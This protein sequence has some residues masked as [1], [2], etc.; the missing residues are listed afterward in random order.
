MDPRRRA[1]LAFLA[2]AAAIKPSFGQS[3]IMTKAIPSTGEPVP[4]IG[5]GTWQTFDAG[6]DSAAR[7]PLREVL[8]L[9][10]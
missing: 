7:A 5:V 10:T 2:A 6:S 3:R 9:M 1:L 4:V 8:K